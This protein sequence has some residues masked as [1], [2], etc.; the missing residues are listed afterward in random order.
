MKIKSAHG[1]EVEVTHVVENHGNARVYRIKAVCGGS[2][3]EQGV[4]FG[5]VDEPKGDPPTLEAMQKTLDAARQR[6][7]NAASW[8]EHQNTT[9]E[10]LV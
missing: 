5:T 4:G 7:A 9:I 1:H 2:V 10:K 3:H 8:Y 6:A